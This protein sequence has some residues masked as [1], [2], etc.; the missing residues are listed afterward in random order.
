MAAQ[1]GKKQRKKAGKAARAAE[2]QPKTCARTGGASGDA[3]RLPECWTATNTALHQQQQRWAACIRSGSASERRH[4]AGNNRS[5]C[6]HI[7]L[8]YCFRVTALVETI[9]GVRFLQLSPGEFFFTTLKVRAAQACC[10][11]SA[12]QTLLLASSAS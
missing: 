9:N 7:L 6:L 11:T 8:V 5:A 10:D 12:G 2:F 4:A 1:W 3:A